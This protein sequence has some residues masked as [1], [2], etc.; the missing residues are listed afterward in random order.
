MFTESPA[1]IRLLP[2]YTTFVAGQVIGWLNFL[3]TPF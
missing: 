2:W 3:I 1:S